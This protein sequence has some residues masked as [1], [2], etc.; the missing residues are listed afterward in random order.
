M[1]RLLLFLLLLVSFNFF[2]QIKLEHSYFN[3]AV[4]RIKLENSGEK[5]YALTYATNEL[6][7]YNSDHTLWKT[8]VLPAT[9]PNSTIP[10]F[11]HQRLKLLM[12]PK[13]K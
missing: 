2:A 3:S 7:F 13:L 5:Y 6:V 11:F 1:K 12:F 8:I 4:T 9:I 10:Y